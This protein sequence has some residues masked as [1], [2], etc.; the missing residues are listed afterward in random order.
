MR[1]VAALFALALSI[2]NVLAAQPPRLVV[3][4]D[5]MGY[6][7]SLGLRTIELAHSLTL[8]FLPSAPHTDELARRGFA[9]GKQIIVHLPMQPTTEATNTAQTL[10]SGLSRHQ[11]DATLRSALAAV[12]FAS[13]ANNHMGSALTAARRQMDWLMHTI[14]TRHGWVFLDSRTS[15]RTVAVDA[16]RAAGVA[17]TSRDV[18]LDNDRDTMAIQRALRHAVSLARKRGAAVAIGHPHPETLS[19][20][21]QALPR[22]VTEGVRLVT[23]FELL[24]AKAAFIRARH[25]SR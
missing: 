22:L 9:A 13:G 14:A 19:V 16:A 6:S 10:S 24:R 11:F 7:R 20:L 23:L 1:F 8:A 18:F 12:P 15:P 5:D 25:R 17:V 21:E 2:G 4:I 3:V